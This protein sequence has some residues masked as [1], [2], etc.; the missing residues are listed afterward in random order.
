MSPFEE[1]NATYANKTL[2]HNWWEDRHM[3]Q[4]ALKSTDSRVFSNDLSS[5]PSAPHELAT[6]K[7]EADFR[8]LTSPAPAKIVKPSLYSSKNL[9]E[10]IATYRDPAPVA[11]TLGHITPE[12]EP[13]G[14]NR[15]LKTTNQVFFSDLPKAAS[16]ASPAYFSQTDRS[17]FVKN[18][19]AT[20]RLDPTHL[21]TS[22]VIGSKGTRGEITR[23]PKESGNP[24]GISVYVDEYAKWQTKLAG[25]PLQDSVKRAQTKYF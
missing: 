10:R 15:H 14:S 18:S 12:E 9:E 5:F 20:D 17:H 1:P 19:L 2:I 7:R 22:E 8:R 4:D 6:S 23:N 3:T 16:T 11:Y 21:G 13:D 24:Y 25:M